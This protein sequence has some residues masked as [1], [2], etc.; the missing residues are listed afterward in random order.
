MDNINILL[1]QERTYAEYWR[2]FQDNRMIL[3]PGPCEKTF[4]RSA[5][6][7]QNETKN[8]DSLK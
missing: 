1:E 4:L 2:I 5:L 6:K 8:Q 3:G 7:I